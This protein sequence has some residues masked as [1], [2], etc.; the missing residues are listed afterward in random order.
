MGTQIIANIIDGVAGRD[1][2]VQS[3]VAGTNISVNNAD[4]ANP[5]V[6]AAALQPLDSDLTAIAA[7]APAND[8]IIQRKAGAW[9]NR[10][11]AQYKTDL[12]LNNVDNTSD[13]TKNAATATL[14]GKTLTTPTIASFTN[15]QHSHTNAAGGGQLSGGALTTNAVTADKLDTAAITLGY[16]ATTSSFST[17]STTAVLVT[18]LTTTVTIPAGGRRIKITGFATDMYASTTVGAALTIWDGTVGSG[19]QLARANG[20]YLSNTSAVVGIVMAVVTPAAGS[21]TYSIGLNTFN[22]GTSANIEAASTYPAFI[23]VEAI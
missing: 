1:G 21:K 7:I 12:A 10:T 14:S 5:I 15:A 13:A 4:A 23:L 20:G 11:V 9:T 16:A 18:G 8:D 6:S 19:T 2:V 22:A 3:I 17:S